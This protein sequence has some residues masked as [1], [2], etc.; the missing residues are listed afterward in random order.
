M[1]S[2][3]IA[4][5]AAIAA[6]PLDD[7][8]RL[9]Y[10]D[11]LDENL[12]DQPIV[13]CPNCKGTQW[14]PGHEGNER[15]SD[16]MGQ[17]QRPPNMRSEFIRLHIAD[18]YRGAKTEHHVRCGE[19]LKLNSNWN[20][21]PCYA[22]FNDTARKCYVCEDTRTMDALMERGF[23]T[24]VP[25]QSSSIWPGPTAWAKAIVLAH[26]ILR[27][28]PTDRIPVRDGDEFVWQTMRPACNQLPTPVFAKLANRYRRRGENKCYN[29]P[30]MAIDAMARATAEVVRELAMVTANVPHPADA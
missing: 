18:H 19:L 7:T 30:A 15:C 27:L 1:H 28:Y 10:A 29:N 8:P 21:L 5:L 2:E 23:I 26:P 6:Q 20:K 12:Q 9:A 25:C 11:W 4:M 3:Q 13:Q 17:E 24:T 14:E 22:C 16:C